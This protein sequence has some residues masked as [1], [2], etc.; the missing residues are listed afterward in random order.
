M[1]SVQ[2]NQ[3]TI[4]CPSSCRTHHTFPQNGRWTF[5]CPF[6]LRN[7]LDCGWFFVGLRILN[8]R[9]AQSPFFIP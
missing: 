5:L 4:L 1:L 7:P 2:V 6:G 9:R 3:N 8:M